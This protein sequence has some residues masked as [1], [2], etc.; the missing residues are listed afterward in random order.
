MTAPFFHSDNKNLKKIQQIV[1]L[2]KAANLAKQVVEA[3]INLAIIA[4]KK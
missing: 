2:T 1:M 3:T 4:K